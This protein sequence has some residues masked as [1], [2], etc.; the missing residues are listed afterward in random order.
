MMMLTMHG[1]FVTCT[2]KFRLHIYITHNQLLWAKL[3]AL[4]GK[5]KPHL[6]RRPMSC[7]WWRIPIHSGP[8][9]SINCPPLTFQSPLTSLSPL[10]PILYYNDDI[11]NFGFL[12]SKQL[13][14]G[15]P[16]RIRFH[17]TAPTW[18]QGLRMLLL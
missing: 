18:N 14:R 1:L 2:Q 4:K 3:I 11:N 17:I 8:L 5:K 9:L 12:D 13:Q 15:S 10:W 16:Q 7:S 6:L